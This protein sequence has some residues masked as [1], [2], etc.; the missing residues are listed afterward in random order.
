METVDM[1][2]ATELEPEAT[3]GY[4][5]CCIIRLWHKKSKLQSEL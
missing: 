4:S 1:M 5:L 3:G 2:E